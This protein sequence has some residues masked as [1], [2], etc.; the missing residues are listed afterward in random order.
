MSYLR[1]GAVGLAKAALH[2]DR[3]APAVVQSRRTLCARCPA[4]RSSRLGRLCVD[5]DCFITAKTLVN[6]EECPRRLW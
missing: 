6:S 4:N 1:H 5:C 3:A 2:I